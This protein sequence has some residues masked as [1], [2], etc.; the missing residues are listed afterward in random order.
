M[1]KGLAVSWKNQG[2]PLR[3][4]SGGWCGDVVSPDCPDLSRWR[5]L[6]EK[7]GSPHWTISTSGW[8]KKPR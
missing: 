4:A 3:I 5:G 8:F 2:R 6:H 7:I 1:R